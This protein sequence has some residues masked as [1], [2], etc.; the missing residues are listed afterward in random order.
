MPSAQDDPIF[1]K[2]APDIRSRIFHSHVSGHSRRAHFGD[3][4]LAM[5]SDDGRSDYI[6][7]LSKIGQLADDV[8]NKF[9]GYVSLEFEAAR[10]RDRVVDSACEL[11]R[12]MDEAGVA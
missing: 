11:F 2:P 5:L 7:W 10:S 1:S 3:I 8:D 6:Q 4:S 9:S 12:M